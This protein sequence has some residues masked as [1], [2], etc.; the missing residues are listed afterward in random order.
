MRLAI[1]CLLLA[2]TLPAA[3]EIYKYTDAKGNTVYTNQPPEGQATETLVLPPT[4]T[5]EMPKP[6][7]PLGGPAIESEKQ[8]AYRVLELTDLPDDGA[9]R[10]NNGS[11]S[12][13]VKLEPSLQPGHRLRLLLDGRPYGQA[14]TGLRLQ[15]SNVDRGEHSL[16]VEVLR[17]EQSI[18]QSTTLTFTVQ[19]VNINSPALRPPPSPAP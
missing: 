6:A 7:A 16:A 11:F 10:A 12:V 8:T 5:V 14:S 19:R 15:L 18:Q 13:G 17:G 1:I 4:N 9:L 2:L 3:A